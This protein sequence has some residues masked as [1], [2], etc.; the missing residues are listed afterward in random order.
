M[1]KITIHTH[2]LFQLRLFWSVEV[3]AREREGRVPH[4]MTTAACTPEGS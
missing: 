2:R 1:T 3:R 4:M